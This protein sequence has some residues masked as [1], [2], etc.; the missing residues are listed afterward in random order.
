[1]CV[2]FVIVL[3]LTSVRCVQLC[4][5]QVGLAVFLTEKEDK[6]AVCMGD[7]KLQERGKARKGKSERRKEGKKEGRKEVRKDEKER[8]KKERKG[9]KKK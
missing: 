6:L 4:G 8:K 2:C 7:D 1:M 9:G 5:E 3:L